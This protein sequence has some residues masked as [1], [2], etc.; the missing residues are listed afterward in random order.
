MTFPTVQVIDEN[1]EFHSVSEYFSK[2]GLADNG[3]KYHVVAVFGS[4]STGKSTLLNALF[5]TKFQVMDDTRRSQTTKGIWMGRASSGTHTGGSLLVPSTSSSEDE[6]ES[7]SDEFIKVASSISPSPE[8]SSVLSSSG[9]Y[10]P[11]DVLILDVEGTDGRERGEDQDFERKSALFALATSEVLIV[12]MWENQVGLYQGANMGLLKTVFEVN[13]TLFGKNKMKSVLLFVI[14]DH[15]GSVPLANLGETIKSDL[16]KQ[17]SEIS[18]PAGLEN[19]RFEDFFD[20]QFYGLPHKLLQAAEFERSAKL[21]S[22]RFINEPY[23]DYIFSPKYHRNVPIDGWNHYAQNVWDQIEQNKDLDL[24]TQQI[25]VARFR[26]E[27]LLNEAWNV[28]EAEVKSRKLGKD[29]SIVDKEFGAHAGQLRTAALELFD[30][31]ASRY[32]KTVFTE[33][34][35]ELQSK[36]DSALAILFEHQLDLVA[37]ELIANFKTFKFDTQKGPTHLADTK[38]ECLGTFDT[39]AKQSSLGLYDYSD[40][41]HHFC[42]QLDEQE[43][44]IKEKEIRKIVTRCNKKIA[45]ALQENLSRYLVKPKKNSWDDIDKYFHRTVEDII[46]PYL[47]FGFNVGE[48]DV[49]KIVLE[50]RKNAW[51]ALDLRLKD[52]IREETVVLRLREYFEQKFRYDEK[53]IPI[54]WKPSDDIE[55]PF[56]SARSEAESLLPIYATTKKSDGTLLVPD[57]GYLEDDDDDDYNQE[58]AN[59]AFSTRLSKDSQEL[60]LERF[61]QQ[62]DAI[63][64]DAKRSVTM[65]A[66]QIPWFIFV[67]IVILGWNE[68]MAVLRSPFLF[69]LALMI[70][71]GAYAVHTLHMWGAVIQVSN[72]VFNETASA[73]KKWLREILE[74]KPDHHGSSQPKDSNKVGESIELKDLPSPG[75]EHK[76]ASEEK[77]PG[78]F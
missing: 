37:F 32:H 19:S 78:G 41:R 35:N 47:E 48:A 13:L 21:L 72:A 8:S 73:G 5:G 59:A 22:E 43:A 26:C 36:L 61:K 55:G 23:K 66:T 38:D 49:D 54:V 45:S 75:P 64:V 56:T 60:I 6:N 17:W 57:V 10:E 4:Q 52:V 34:K 11:L 58:E 50:I 62:A 46:A 42:S 71:G 65:S 14:R 69:V 29:T 67:L 16:Q 77:M 74:I 76:H 7:G 9:S 30:T 70:G 28:F 40:K 2:V 12:N 44:R 63:Y 25:L 39:F 24:P 1:K 27:E 51:Q 20:V 15:L 53:K 33:K 31:M 68:F 3:L 18:K